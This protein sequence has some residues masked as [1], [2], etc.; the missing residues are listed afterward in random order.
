VRLDQRFFAAAFG[1]E[2]GA[3]GDLVV[4]SLRDL[5]TPAAG[6][7]RFIYNLLGEPVSRIPE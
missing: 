7:M 1:G 4:R 2:G 5:D 6:Y 3:V